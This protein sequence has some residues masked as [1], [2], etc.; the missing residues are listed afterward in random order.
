VH[1][2]NAFAAGGY[3]GHAGLFGTAEEVYRIVNMLREHYMGI[4]H[5]LLQ[6]E[7]VR[8]FFSR[9]E[10]VGGCTFALGWDTPSALNSSAGR[11]FSSGSV[12]HLGFTG[13]SVWMDL[14]KDVTVVFL[15]NRVHPK[16]DN[17]KIKAFRPWI[18][19][20]I[21]EELGFGK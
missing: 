16:R 11:L 1:D 12:G 8:E 6:P 10:F 21:M 18:H 4:R 15:T 5:D 20:L 13:T 3:S 19:D 17:E 14:E 9:Q 2:D 7:T